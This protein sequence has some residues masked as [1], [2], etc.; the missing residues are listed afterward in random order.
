MEK[1]ENKDYLL[2]LSTNLLL[3]TDPL[4]RI[5]YA[6]A[7]ARRT[8]ERQDL[9]GLSLEDLQP[10]K[11]FRQLQHGI[12][13]T[14]ASGLSNSLL[15]EIRR[16]SYM[17]LIRP[18]ENKAALCLND[19]TE[20]AELAAQLDKVSRRLE[21]AERTTLLGYWELDLH[22]RRFYWSAEMYRIFGVDPHANRPQHNYIRDLIIPEDLPLYKEKLRELLQTSV[23]VEGLLR[24]QRPDKKQVYCFFKASLRYENNR[25]FIAGTFQD[26]TLLIE[27]QLQLEEAVRR[28]EELSSAKSYFLAQ[29]SHDLR[30]PMQAL[31]IFISALLDEKLSPQQQNLVHKIDESSSNLNNL[32][33]NLLDISRIEA[34]GLAFH[35]ASFDLGKLLSGL[36]REYRDL[37]QSRKIEFRFIPFRQVVFSDPLLI[38]RIIRNLLNNAFK[39][40][41][42]KILLG[43]KRHKKKILI[44]VLDNGCG[45]SPEEQSK[46]FGDFYQSRQCPS[47]KKMGAGLGL[48]IVS[49]IAGLLGADIRVYSQLGKGSCFTLELPYKKTPL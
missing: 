9:T 15:L 7:V 22:T 4:G 18:E 34:G 23:P 42:N 19:I 13:E 30:Q 32:L 27:T 12:K 21:F 48:A 31:K 38:E 3:E 8:F 46:I 24:I 1:R 11:A 40:T 43:I 6:N 17:T 28:A 49:R 2:D 26:L 41:Q 20:K 33:D 25:R 5:L 16:R 10:D 37:A 35:P 36:A 14:L 47:Q 45:I 44:M 39:Y 29:A